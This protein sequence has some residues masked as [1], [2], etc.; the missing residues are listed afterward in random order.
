MSTTVWLPEPDE[1]VLSTLNADGSRRWLRPRLSRGV[2]LTWRRAVAYALI[3]IFTLIPYIYVNGKPLMLLDIANRR[4][5]LFG[6]TFLPTDAVFLALLMVSLL[7]GIF[8]FTALFGRV[9]CGWACPQTVYMEFLYRPIERFFEGTAGKG[10]APKHFGGGLRVV[11]KYAT[12]MLASF[13]LANTFLSYFVGV[14]QLRHWI[15]SPPMQHPGWF[16]VMLVTTLLM[17]FNFSYFREQTCL[18]ACPY[19]RFQSAL[20]DRQSLIITY[21]QARGEPRGKM[22]NQPLPVLSGDVARTRANALGDCVDC[23][24]CVTTCPTG[25]DIRSGLQMECV[26]C[27]QCIDACDAVM[28]KVHRPLGLI[29]YSSE[30]KLAGGKLKPIRARTAFYGT[31]LTILLS[32][33]VYNLV[34]RPPVNIQVLRVAG[35]PYAELEDHVISNTVRV[36]LTNRTDAP[37]AYTVEIAG[38]SNSRILTGSESIRLSPFEAHDDNMRI[39]TPRNAFK[40]GHCA[41]TLRVRDDAGYQKDIQYVLNG[42]PD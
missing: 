20:L 36:K 41:V 7:I 4:F 33:L 8:L 18:V 12:F 6:T 23:G 1:P 14:E 21:D 10:G 16:G 3:G 30:A 38:Q 25:I 19:G 24:L 13:F 11:G 35:L 31:I 2:F 28:A 34:T 5:T 40:G 37:R 17:L 42:P 39:V 29:R 22:K 26:G 27:A 9:W 15:L 32:V